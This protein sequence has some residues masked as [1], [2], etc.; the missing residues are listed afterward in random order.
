MGSITAGVCLG[1]VLGVGCG[2]VFGV[3]AFDAGGLQRFVTLVTPWLALQA[4]VDGVD[5]L[6]S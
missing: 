4:G 2:V 1:V 5:A 3:D 6:A